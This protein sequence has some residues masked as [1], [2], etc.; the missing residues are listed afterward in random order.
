[1]GNLDRLI[2]LERFGEL[3]AALQP[4]ELAVVALRMDGLNLTEVGLLLGLTRAAVSQRLTLAQR[5]MVARYP[6]LEREAAARSRKR[7]SPRP[8][9]ETRARNGITR[10]QA[11][12]LEEMRA[13]ARAGELIYPKALAIRMG[14]HA[15]EVGRNLSALARAGLVRRCKKVGRNCQ[16]YEVVQERF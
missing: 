3:L 4:K 10:R 1:M 13:M 8:H 7:G 6:E 16:P 14:R 12:T 2:A 11:E 5:R 15:S 9:R